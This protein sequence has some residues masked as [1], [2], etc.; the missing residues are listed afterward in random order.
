MRK[1]HKRTDNEQDAIAEVKD[2]GSYFLSP[3]WIDD[4]ILLAI[5]MGIEIEVRAR[6]VDNA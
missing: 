4:N 5:W 1:I 6:E 2:C 3:G